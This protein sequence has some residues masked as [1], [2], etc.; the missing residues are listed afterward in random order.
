[1]GFLRLW[2]TYGTG[3]IKDLAQPFLR[4]VL[5]PS[6]AALTLCRGG[7]YCSCAGAGS[8]VH[9]RFEACAVLQRKAGIGGLGGTHIQP[10]GTTR[11]EAN[12]PST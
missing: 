7:L 9:W 12:L 10:C 6:Y 11:S 4:L 1:M 3:R 8:E 2:P 5:W